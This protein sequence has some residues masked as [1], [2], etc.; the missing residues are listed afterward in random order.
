MSAH[1]SLVHVVVGSVAA[2][3]RDLRHTLCDRCLQKKPPEK[4]TAAKQQIPQMK[5]C[6]PD[7]MWGT[8]WACS[9]GESLCFRT[10]V[11]SFHKSILFTLKSSVRHHHTDTGV[12]SAYVC[13]CGVATSDWFLT[14]VGAGLK[15]CHMYNMKIRAP[16]KTSLS[17]VM[18]EE[19]F[20]RL[21]QNS[22]KKR[23]N[24]KEGPSFSWLQICLVLQNQVNG[25]R[26][27]LHSPGNSHRGIRQSFLVFLIIIAHS[28]FFWL[29][30][31]LYLGNNAW[32]I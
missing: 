3:D 23:F 24:S 5:K 29:W 19:A 15:G 9:L 25:G 12:V 11:P 28:L 18:T 4:S 22:N 32:F 10:I 2:A 27:S 8:M 1:H 26:I 14:G 30:H 7:L 6:F 16:I 13:V 21:V 20:A 17:Y 31:W